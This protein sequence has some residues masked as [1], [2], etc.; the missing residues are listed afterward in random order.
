MTVGKA[1]TWAGDSGW[2]LRE[3]A[4]ARSGGLVVAAIAMLLSTA[5]AR[6][7]AP[8]PEFDLVHRARTA[9]AELRAFERLNAEIVKRC[10]DPVTG[11]YGD[12]REEF[13]AELDHA[14]ALDKALQRR[15]PDN[16]APPPEDVRLKPFVESDGQVLYSRCLRWSTLLIQRE[17]PVRADIGATL[18]FLKDNEARLKAIIA[19]DAAWQA[20]R[21]AGASP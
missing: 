3:N 13:R 7:D 5:I 2:A 20:W 6:A 14:H 9:L 1:L 8:S 18:R 12:W 19:D 10:Q 4:M 16:A 15:A 17:S 21:A 11:A